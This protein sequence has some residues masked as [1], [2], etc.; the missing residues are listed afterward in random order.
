MIKQII[1]EFQ[2]TSGKGGIRYDWVRK[3]IHGELCK[4]L[5]F[6][7]TSKWY[8]Y[9]PESVLE[10]ETHQIVWDFEIK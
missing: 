3:V 6:D 2:L 1:S 9:K 4:K 8:T 5:K 7:Y 10:N